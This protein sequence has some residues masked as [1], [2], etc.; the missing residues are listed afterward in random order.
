MYSFYGGRPGNSFV[1]V[2]VF[3]S[4]DEM[5][6]KFSNGPDYT[7][8]HYDEYVMIN[9]KNRNNKDNGKIYRRGYNFTDDLGGA[10]YVGCIAGPAGNAPALE[11]TTPSNI[12]DIIDKQGGT[13]DSNG[14]ANTNSLNL[15]PGKYMEDDEEKFND[16]IT[17]RSCN[18]LDANG[19]T[20]TV[21]VGLTSIPYTVIDFTTDTIGPY[22]KSS[23]EQVGGYSDHP[24]YEKWKINIPRGI[25]GNS[26]ENLTIETISENSNIIYPDGMDTT[27]IEEG[28]K[29][30]VYNKRIY[31]DSEDGEIETQENSA[32]IKKY[33]CGQI[34]E[35]KNVSVD[36]TGQLT[37]NYTDNNVQ[38]TVLPSKLKWIKEVS[39]TDEGTLQ[40][41]WNDNTTSTSSDNN[42]IRWIEDVTVDPNTQKLKIQWNN[43]DNGYLIGE[44]INYIIDMTVA[45]NN[46]LLVKYSDPAQRQDPT[47]YTNSRNEV[48]AG[49]TDIGTIQQDTE[50]IGAVNNYLNGILGGTITGQNVPQI[51]SKSDL[52][53]LETEIN[54][55]LTNII[56]Y[57]DL[58]NKLDGVPNDQLDW[59]YPSRIYIQRNNSNEITDV[60]KD[61]P[62]SYSPM[63][64]KE[65]LI[66]L[67]KSQNLDSIGN[68]LNNHQ[69]DFYKYQKQMYERVYYVGQNPRLTGE[70]NKAYRTTTFASKRFYSF[71][72]ISNGS[73]RAHFSVTLDKKLPIY[74]LEPINSPE[75]QYENKHI[76]I[77]RKIINLSGSM[78]S[79]ESG[80]FDTLRKKQ[81]RRIENSSSNI[82]GQY[83]PYQFLYTDPNDGYI[84]KSHSWTQTFD[85][86]TYEFYYQRQASQDG[87]T[88]GFEI[89]N[90]NSLE[91]RM[92]KKRK[93]GSTIENVAFRLN[94][95]LLEDTNYTSWGGHV[96]NNPASGEGSTI[97]PNDTPFLFVGTIELEFVI[98]NFN[99]PTD[100]YPP[101]NNNGG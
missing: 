92:Q 32:I 44:P 79:V 5:V 66:S 33:Y 9:T 19:I 4:K 70:N 77:Q 43:D 8:V 24:F 58:K 38:P 45:S 12:Q 80:Q 26:I 50:I 28:D 3:E 101:L 10:E 18:L 100:V 51:A 62:G 41:T 57:G 21:Y 46:H 65:Y 72:V 25:K 40:F 15:V 63:L 97:V 47:E 68:L 13:H 14:S 71:G 69:N 22:Q 64:L 56:E 86:K 91:I 85:N 98:N 27:G 29:V 17:W 84:E 53:E 74:D 59:I 81:T 87:V 54:A 95:H 37:I 73:K 7:A 90:E 67:I 34:N 94:D 11:F 75:G 61:N 55:D 23:V 35:I 60:Q 6:Q 76:N 1:I 48:S 30:L 96:N 20:S 93:Q 2:A 88:N 89:I 16:E 82:D 42:K 39:L 36:D 49:W 83:T 52:N 78:F 31:D 99:A